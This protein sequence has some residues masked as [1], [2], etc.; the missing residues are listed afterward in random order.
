MFSFYRRLSS[1]VPHGKSDDD[2]ATAAE[3]S[4]TNHPTTLRPPATMH[5]CQTNKRR[6]PDCTAAEMEGELMAQQAA[7]DTMLVKRIQEACAEEKAERAMDLASMLHLEKS[8][9]IAI[10]VCT[11]AV[12]RFYVRTRGSAFFS[13]VVVGSLSL[14]VCRP[15]GVPGECRACQRKKKR[16]RGRA[17]LKGER[18]WW[19]ARERDCDCLSVENCGELPLTLE[20]VLSLSPSGIFL[21]LSLSESFFYS[22]SYSLAMLCFV[23][24]VMPLPLRRFLFLRILLRCRWRTT[25][26]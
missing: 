17:P 20:V 7:L 9:S 5:A 15:P 4:T 11:H 22:Q 12:P 1:T 13:D 24:L 26:G 18:G 25:T 3:T 16:W 21:E 2:V 19:P 6:Q 10:K 23:H 14:N 8:Y